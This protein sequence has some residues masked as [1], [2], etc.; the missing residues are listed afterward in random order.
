MDL[1]IGKFLINASHTADD[2]GQRETLYLLTKISISFHTLHHYFLHL[3][4]LARVSMGIL[5]ESCLQTSFLYSVYNMDVP[6]HSSGAMGRAHW[7]YAK[8]AAK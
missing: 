6:L 5:D 3:L 7:H 2:Q 4:V 8:T 1:D